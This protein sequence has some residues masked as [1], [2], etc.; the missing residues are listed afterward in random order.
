[1]MRLLQRQI[2]SVTDFDYAVFS[3]S[4]SLIVWRC[5]I[6][7]IISAYRCHYWLTQSLSSIL[8][9]WFVRFT[10]KIIVSH[11]C[12]QTCENMA[13]YDQKEEVR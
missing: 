8:N 6:R 4:Q 12:D 1:M 13:F 7:P 10:F 3:H 9:C 11:F 2:S 5:L